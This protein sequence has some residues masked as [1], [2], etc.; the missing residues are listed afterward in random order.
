MGVKGTAPE[1]DATDSVVPPSVLL[2]PLHDS[3]TEAKSGSRGPHH[4]ITLDR[5]PPP[6][7]HKR[8]DERD[9]DIGLTELN[10]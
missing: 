10:T 7:P 2:T 1:C 3:L 9:G 4:V 5:L 8:T 6:N